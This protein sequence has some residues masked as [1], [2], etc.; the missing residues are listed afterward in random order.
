MDI[1]RHVRLFTYGTTERTM[2]RRRESRLAS[3]WWML[4]EFELFEW[5]GNHQS[6]GLR[7]RLSGWEGCQI[8][9]LI[10]V[11]SALLFICRTFRTKWRIEVLSTMSSLSKR[12]TK[13]HVAFSETWT[14]WSRGFE[15]INQLDIKIWLFWGGS[16][17]LAGVVRFC[18]CLLRF[19]CIWSWFAGPTTT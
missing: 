14:F 7:V 17:D 13:H 11:S 2:M 3:T 19:F 15:E 16:L 18:Q 6:T 5:F 4:S 12:V 10:P 8:P 1:L 9:V